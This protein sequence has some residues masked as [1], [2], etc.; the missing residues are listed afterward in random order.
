[1]KYISLWWVFSRKD[2]DY[3]N[4]L[5]LSL[6]HNPNICEEM[7][8]KCITIYI[9]I[10]TSY[11]IN[12]FRYNYVLQPTYMM[13]MA[14]MIVLQSRYLSSYYNWVTEEFEDTKGVIRIRKSKKDRQLNG[15]GGYHIIID[16]V[17]LI[18]WQHMVTLYALVVLLLYICICSVSGLFI[19]AGIFW[20]SIPK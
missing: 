4:L 19:R 2:C 3:V 1:M 11:V 13:N 15:K 16:Q 6:S 9:Y 20:P 8:S 14:C 18:F 17:K 10:R 12:T 5:N 7:H